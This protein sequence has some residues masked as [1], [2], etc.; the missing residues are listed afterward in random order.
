MRVISYKVYVHINKI[1]GKLYI[2]QTSEDNPENRY[3]NGKNY[4]RCPYFHNAI[5]KYG[6]DNFEHIILVDDVTKEQAD[7]IEKELIKKYKTT[8][9]RF[10]Y[11]LMDGG[12][13]GKHNKKSIEKMKLNHADVSGK[14]N[15]MSNKHHSEKSKQK[16]SEHR[17]SYVG[18]NNPNYGKECS[19]LAK[20][21][22]SEINSK[23]VLQ[24]DDN[25]NVIKR[26]NSASEA[27]RELKISICDISRVCVNLRGTAGGFR[28]KFENE[29]R[30]ENEIKFV[31]KRKT[32][33]RPII[34]K[35]KDGNI[36]AKYNSI[37][38]AQEKTK[39]T[40]IANCLCGRYKSAGGYIWEYLEVV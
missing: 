37:K 31:D 15:P 4:M 28:W 6:W 12:S 9:P 26:W 13:N 1:N 23:P 7:I 5:L 17:P 40:S 29:T 19:K 22:S 36:V 34:Q 32:R 35:T 24:M 11:N 16:M 33:T 20:E 3:K 25:K 21:K 39:I 27:G 38:E 18:E 8:N 10:G 2:G 30:D 14:N